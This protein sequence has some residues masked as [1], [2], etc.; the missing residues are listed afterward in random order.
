METSRV[1]CRPSLSA[2]G[3]VTAMDSAQKASPAAG[4]EVN[5]LQV[6]FAMMWKLTEGDPV[7]RKMLIAAAEGYNRQ[8]ARINRH[9]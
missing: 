8:M 2:G 3:S 4:Q 1:H 5:V 6:L 9:A 7:A